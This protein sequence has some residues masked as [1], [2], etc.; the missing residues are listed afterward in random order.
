MD[1]CK[2]LK[3]AETIAV[4][5][6]SSDPTKTS[7][8]IARYLVAAGYNVVGVNPLVNADEVD[9]IKIYKNLIDIPHAVD[10]IDVFRKSEHIKD[11]L[12]DVLSIKPK[13]LWL[14]LGII[15]DEVIDTVKAAGI[16]G[17]Q[18]RCIYVE[19]NNCKNK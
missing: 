2:I 15:N 13:V 14:Q 19:H 7:R 12:D 9:S 6:I 17:I 3:D 16:V 11:V 1:Y 5:G 4:V 18:N 8:K 10:I